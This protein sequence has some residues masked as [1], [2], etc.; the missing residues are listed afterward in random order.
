[1]QLFVLLSTALL[2]VSSAKPLLSR[3]YVVKETHPVP[4]EFSRIGGA[5]GDHLLR[6]QIGVKQGQFDVLEKHLWESKS[7]IRTRQDVKANSI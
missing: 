1:M 5:P 6:L 3:R 2:A 7:A 4:S